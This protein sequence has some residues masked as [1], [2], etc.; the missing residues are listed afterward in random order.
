MGEI[1]PNLCLPPELVIESADDMLY[2]I[3]LQYKSSRINTK[4]KWF[5]NHIVVFISQFIFIAKEITLCLLSND[6]EQL[7]IMFDAH[8]L[9]VRRHFN[10]LFSATVVLSICSQ[11][12]YYYNYRNGIKPTFLR[13][14]QMM[15][16][17]VP[18]KAMGLNNSK[19]I[20]SITKKAKFLF[21]FVDFNMRSFL[22]LFA[23]LAVL[24]VYYYQWTE[25]VLIYGFP[26]GI[27]LAI[28]SEYYLGIL[29]YQYLYFYMICLYFRIKINSLNESLLEMQRRNRFVRI[30]ETLQSIDSLY[31]EI[32]EYNTTFWSKFLGIFWF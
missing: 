2:R 17:S 29:L 32:S 21:K 3:G 19:D 1:N 14:F 26:N 22:P 6:H 18:P 5:F 11:I 31:S 12:F 24:F 8:I 20:L 25:Y 7:L 13:L 27:F 9:P 23:L 15:S 4:R 30:R 10:V 28:F 16:G